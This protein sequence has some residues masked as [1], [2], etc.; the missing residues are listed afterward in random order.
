MV[1]AR[2]ETVMSGHP[3]VQ[4][5]SYVCLSVS[6]R[7]EGMD[8]ATLTKAVDPFFTTKE[9]G[10]GTGLGLSI[11]LGIINNHQGS[12]HV[13]SEDGKGAEFITYL[14]VNGSMGKEAK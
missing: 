4:P 7:G 3:T 14:P 12:L 11:S 1:A 5:G 9:V 6:D 10:K 8:E 2:P 13:V